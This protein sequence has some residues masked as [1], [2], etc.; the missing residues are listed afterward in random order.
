MVSWSGKYQDRHGT[1]QVRIDNDGRL[2]TVAI[3]GVQFAGEDFDALAPIGGR[4]ASDLAFTLSDGCLCSCVLEWDAPVPV[5]AGFTETEGLLR[6]RL[7]LGD[8][9]G[10]YG[11]LTAEE[12]IM[13]LH[14]A[15][16]IYPT[17]RDYGSFEDALEDIHRQLPPDTYVKACITCAWSD[18]WPAGTGLIGP[19]AC[20]R[21]VKDAYRQVRT[22]RDLFAIWTIRTGDVQETY[23]CPEFERRRAD[24]GY[25]GSFPSPTRLLQ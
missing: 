8:P 1:E 23:L 14:A 9:G 6:C 4:P 3:R 12:L 24:T 18:Y 15:T 7:I 17:E 2:L 25:R 13:A 11:G 19:M 22:K 20:F 21:G 16:S 5:V 10:P